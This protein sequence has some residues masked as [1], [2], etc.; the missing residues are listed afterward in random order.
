MTRRNFYVM[1]A[2]I[3][4]FILAS[5]SKPIV[6]NEHYATN[7]ISEKFPEFDK[8][9][10]M[11][12]IDADVVVGSQSISVY[13][14]DNVTPYVELSVT[15]STLNIRYKENITIV[16]DDDTKVYV[17]MPSLT[18]V[19]VSGSG[20]VDVHGAIATVETLSVSGSG[21]IEVENLQA[22]EVLAQVNG[23]GSISL[24]GIAAVGTYDVSGSGEIDA[25]EMQVGR[26]SA[27]VNGSGSIDCY[28]IEHLVATTNG[29]GEIEYQ[30]PHTLVVESNGKNIKRDN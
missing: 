11:G 29:S 13:G 16:G 18:A 30:G 5:C 12:N 10:V 7:M 2:V 22:D 28:A 6:P 15:N 14:A 25:N 24:H 23:S 8:I 3:A 17:S 9:A 4:T 1:V 27:Q 26:L 21:E 20:E 19:T